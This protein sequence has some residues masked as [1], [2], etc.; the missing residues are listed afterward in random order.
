MTEKLYYND[1]YI[2]HFNAEIID[3]IRIDAS[4]SAIILDKTAFFPEGGGQPGD[5][6]SIDNLSIY[7]T[8]IINDIIYHY[9]KDQVNL[10]KGCLVDCFI[11][12][13]KRFTAMQAHSGEHILS[14][15]A[16]QMFSAENVGFHMDNDFIMTVDFNIPLSKE[17]LV[18]LE[19]K[20]NQCIYDNL[21]I[22]CLY[23][24]DDE[25][26]DFEFRSKKDISGIVR[27]VCIDE[28]DKC[29]CCAPHLKLTGSV[30]VLKILQSV[31]HRGGVRLTVVC[32]ATAF[33]DYLM[34]HNSTLRISSMLCSPHDGTAHAVHTL[35]EQN[36]ELKKQIN[37]QKDKFLD[38]ITNSIKQKNIVVEFFDNI[39]MNELISLAEKIRKSNNTEIFLFSG[40]D[41]DGYVFCFSSERI[42]MT[43]FINK[44]R[45]V[46]KASGGGRGNLIQGKVSALQ[47]E[48]N[49]Y[50]R[51]EAMI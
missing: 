21:P 14:G 20:A 28:T 9:T 41:T 37:E 23:L 7:D 43:E 29:A 38:Y 12:W 32:G 11:N 49:D 50:I 42:P 3:I 1:S 13:K 24:S 30:G 19:Q 35:I 51:K 17:Q 34:K 26:S 2:K 39:S 6:G 18:I 45:K 31:S 44:F 4:V 10:T 46:F 40:N 15:L 48:L 36:K 27:I 25:L 47:S 33:D 22:S 5:S 8:Q 16:H